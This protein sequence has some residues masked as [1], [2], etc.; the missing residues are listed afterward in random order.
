MEMK[1]SRKILTAIFVVLLSAALTCTIAMGAVTLTFASSDFLR[2]HIA[3]EELAN[4]CNQQLEMKF[5]V[6]EKETGIPA[7]VFLTVETDYPTQTM[8]G[9][10]FTNAFGEED[11]SLY[12][13]TMVDYFYGLC[14][15]YLD[16]NEIPYDD[17]RIKNAAEGAA[18]LY[19]EAVGLHNVDPIEGY[20][21][22]VSHTG[23]RIAFATLGAFAV[24]VLA[25]MLMY[26][27]KY[28]AYVKIFIGVEAAGVALLLG[29]LLLL[30][31]GAAGRITIQPEAYRAAFEAITRG[32]FLMLTAVGAVLTVGAGF[33]VKFAFTRE[34]A[35]K[36]E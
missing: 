25:I 20:I 19:S 6:Y 4:E 17:K 13:A 32:Y 5:S 30:F 12:S 26:K 35:K 14:T 29:G 23:G 34:Y 7:R 2:N 8:L 3:T 22:T 1:K 27:S 33:G 28:L 24:C 31:S 16:G 15:E 18:Q 10:A 21:N 9:R 36:K 11:T